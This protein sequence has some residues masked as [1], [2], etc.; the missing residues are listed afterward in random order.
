MP[1][2]LWAG[3]RRND[4]ARRICWEICHADFEFSLECGMV[5]VGPENKTLFRTD[6]EIKCEKLGFMGKSMARRNGP[7]V[8]ARN[9]EGRME[10]S[11]LPFHAP[12]SMM[13]ELRDGLR[14]PAVSAVRD[15][16][17]AWRFYHQFRTDAG[18][19]L[20]HP[21]LGA[22]SPVLSHD[23]V[24]L[25][26]TLQTIVEASLGDVLQEAI[27]AA[28]PGV[29]WSA[30][31]E[32]GAFQLCVRP[33]EL[34]RPMC[35]AELS[36]GT[37]RYFCLLAALLSPKPPPLLVLNEPEASLHCGLMEPLADLIAQVRG[38]T[39][40]FVVTHSEVLADLLVGACDAKK[41]QLVS[42]EG[43]TR[44]EGLGGAKRAWS[45]E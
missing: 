21:R 36:D 7:V 3:K 22:W 18:S 23:G 41:V 9:E 45:F 19:P 5:S 43:E 34:N 4:E 14:Y 27:D 26:A 24:N 38:E 44:P 30:A 10:A 1:S 31:D 11:A 16:M 25:A 8:E 29:E 37:L 20:R 35:A 6:P 39:Q 40:I 28:F 32:S 12:E 13:S 42:H 17:L 33:P 15:T 2:A